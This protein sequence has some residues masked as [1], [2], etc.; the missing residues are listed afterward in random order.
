MVNK[1]VSLFKVVTQRTYT[2][3]KGVERKSFFYALVSGIGYVV[4]EPKWKTLSDK[5]IL[6]LVAREIS[7]EEFKR[8]VK[9][10][11]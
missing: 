8:A 9:D 5:T 4:I 10:A 11:E 3:N 2:D 7:E 6:R 1:A